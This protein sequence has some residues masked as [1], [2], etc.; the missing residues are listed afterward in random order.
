MI[1]LVKNWN[2]KNRKCVACG[3]TKSVKY[4]AETIK[5]SGEWVP[6]CNK[7]AAMIDCEE[8]VEDYK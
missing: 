2:K 5:G 7:C 6:C 4:N 1:K 8:V 3:T